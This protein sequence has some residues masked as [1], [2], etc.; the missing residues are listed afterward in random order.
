VGDR[1]LSHMKIE[2][3]FVVDGERKGG[4]HFTVNGLGRRSY[5]SSIIRQP[6]LGPRLRTRSLRKCRR[7][8]FYRN[9]S[10]QKEAGV[11]AF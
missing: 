2:I 9:S 10:C 5:P 11:S 8:T 3:R 7:I 6:R 1:N 4:G